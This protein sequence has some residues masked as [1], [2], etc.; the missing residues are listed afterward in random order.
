MYEGV[1]IVVDGETGK[2][3]RLR[4]CRLFCLIRKQSFWFFSS[5]RSE[6]LL[7]SIVLYYDYCLVLR[8]DI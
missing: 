1:G 7:S 4:L 6:N 8:T 2:T 5:C 3:K